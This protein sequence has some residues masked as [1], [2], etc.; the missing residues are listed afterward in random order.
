MGTGFM[1]FVLE[2]GFTTATGS[3]GRC[4]GVFSPHV[5][6]R[7]DGVGLLLFFLIPQWTGLDSGALVQDST[8]ASYEIRSNVFLEDDFSLRNM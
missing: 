1:L 6:F 4:I 7:H 3:M 2:C 8:M 5:S